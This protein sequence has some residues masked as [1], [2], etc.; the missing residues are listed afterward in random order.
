LADGVTVCLVCGT[1]F[2]PEEHRRWTKDGYAIVR[3]PSCTLLFR[4]DLPTAAELDK[5]YGLDYFK[6]DATG[7]LDYVAD[8]DVHR[9][10]ARRRLDTL[11]RVVSRG[12][13]LDV[14]AAAGFFVAEARARSWDAVGIDVSEPMVAWGR[15][16]LAAPLERAT[17]AEPGLPEGSLDALT[18]WDYIEHSLDPAADLARAH[19]LLRPGGVLALSTGDAAAAVARLQGS[20]WH[21]LTPRHHNFFF[22]AAT[23]SDLLAR[24]GFELVSLDHRGS[25]YPLRYLA[26]KLGTLAP[27]RR[28]ERLTGRLAS[29]RLGAVTVP[30]NLWDIVTVVARRAAE[31]K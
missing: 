22:T 25:R 16:T 9:A 12:R 24:S 23:L 27:S 2:P 1:S 14:G 17:L 18:M 7:Y 11:E 21:L 28:L 4:R 8:E 6:G 30:L 19:E 20:R 5:I 29:T 3:C 10:V 15:E 26:H 31:K 13:L